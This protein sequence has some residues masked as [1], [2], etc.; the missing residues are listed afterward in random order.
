MS[1]GSLRPDGPECLAEPPAFPLVVDGVFPQGSRGPDD[2]S[3]GLVGGLFDNNSADGFLD[4]L[5]AGASAGVRL[6][7]LHQVQE[8]SDGRVLVVPSGFVRDQLA[9][10]FAGEL[11]SRAAE[12]AIDRVELVVDP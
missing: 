10:R 9:E 4:G 2:G 6:G 12:L 11:R 8:R 7:L 5:R 1:P 3:S